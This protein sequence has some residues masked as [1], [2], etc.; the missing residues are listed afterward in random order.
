MRLYNVRG[1]K[2][3]KEKVSI[4]FAIEWKRPKNAKG[5]PFKWGDTKNQRIDESWSLKYVIYRWVRHS[6]GAIAYIGETQLPLF[7]RI[8]RYHSA[9]SHNAGQGWANYK[10]YC[11][12]RKLTRKKDYL[13]LEYCN[14][15]SG[16]F[17]NSLFNRPMLLILFEV[18]L[19]KYYK[20]YLQ[21]R[22]S[23]PPEYRFGIGAD[24]LPIEYDLIR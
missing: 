16:F 12:Q 21:S 7:R 22:R 18:L 11:E 20:P 14:D 9:K 23:G 4:K 15:T 8:N 3:P 1:V 24:I 19:I 17:A 6:D 2:M 10:V 5:E 13:Y